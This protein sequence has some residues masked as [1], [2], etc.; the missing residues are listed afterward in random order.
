MPFSMKRRM[1]LIRGN[2]GVDL[3]VNSGDYANILGGED[4]DLITNY[5][6]KVNIIGDNGKGTASSAD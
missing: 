6:N 1:T 5:G 3:I 4:D 2:A